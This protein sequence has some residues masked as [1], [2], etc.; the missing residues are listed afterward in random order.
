MKRADRLTWSREMDTGQKKREFRRWASPPSPMVRVPVDPRDVFIEDGYRLEPVAVGLTYPTG[1]TFDDRGNLYVGEGGFSY[2]PAKAEGLGRILRL[3]RDGTMTE[4]ASGLQG[5]M[6]GMTW[7]RGAFYVAEGGFPGRI[8]RVKPDGTKQVLVD[9]LR[10]GGDHYTSEVAFGPDGRMY[11]GVGTFTN[12]AVVGVDNFVFGWLPDFPTEHDV[13]YRSLPLKGVNYRSANPFTLDSPQPTM[14]VTGGFKP[15]GVPSQPGEVVQGSIFANGVIYT[16]NPDGS[17][18]QVIA[19]GLRNP[20]AL[21]FSPDNRLWAVDQGYD[22]RGSRPVENAPDPLWEIKTGGWYGYPDF[23]AGKPITDP[24]FQSPGKPPAQFLLEEH[25]SLA[26]R[27]RLLF[28]P[29]SATMKFDFSTNPHFGHAGEVFVAQLGSGAPV[30]GMPRGTPGYR[31]VRADL[32]TGKVMNFLVNRNPLYGGTG[33]QRPVGVKFD[34]TG[35]EM[36]VLDFG[37]MEANLAGVIPYAQSGIL[38]RITRKRF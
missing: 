15:F 16:A 28:P 7:H 26:G 10:S 38:W 14:A 12:S 35:C 20:F 6:T 30:T 21:G 3:N 23:V 17:G 9:G 31:V 36:Y 1:L 33:P 25:P 8:S 32:R 27:P 29:H 34:P 18:L 11:F 4:I 24:Q 19:D 13:P 37:T 2:G 5:P 22:N